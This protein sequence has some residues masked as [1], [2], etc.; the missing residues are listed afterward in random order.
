MILPLSTYVFS[1]DSEDNQDEEV[2]E[3]GDFENEDLIVESKPIS[4]S[5]E[6]IESD[7][8]E[9]ILKE[10]EEVGKVEEV[11]KEETSSN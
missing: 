7:L 10:A 8:Y 6:T 2:E 3:V 1:Q 4:Y 9:P 11:T 5:T